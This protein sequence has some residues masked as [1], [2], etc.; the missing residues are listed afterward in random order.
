[1]GKKGS[2]K[3][4]WRELS[5]EK[6]TGGNTA[7]TNPGLCP[8]LRRRSNVV[9]PVS[10]G[11]GNSRPVSHAEQQGSHQQS[12]RARDDFTFAGRSE[13]F[14]TFYDE[15]AVT[16][17]GDEVQVTPNVSD[18]CPLLRRASALLKLRVDTPQVRAR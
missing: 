12:D 3:Q 1:M 6:S 10:F 11:D 13:R 15:Q 2:V 14:I 5:S 16:G 9:K 4:D 18:V 17:N 8:D 7:S